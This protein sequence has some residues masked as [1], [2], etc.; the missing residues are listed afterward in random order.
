M[1]LRMVRK[2]ITQNGNG[3]CHNNLADILQEKLIPF[4]AKAEIS[5]E[6]QLV[7]SL[8]EIIAKLRSSPMAKELSDKCVIG[9]GGKFSAGK[10]CFINSLISTDKQ[11]LTEGQNPTTS[12]PTYINGPPKKGKQT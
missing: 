8:Q 6:S 12:I 9:V 4:I 10:S 11:L 1:S 2:I 7:S 5:G 3:D